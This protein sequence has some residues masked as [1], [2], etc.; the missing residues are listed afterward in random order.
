MAAAEASPRP[1]VA[2]LSL[3]NVL[4]TPEQL[5]RSPSLE[6]GVPAELEYDLRIWG[7]QFIQELGICLRLF[8]QTITHRGLPLLTLFCC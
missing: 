5:A 1:P 6:D 8:A 7:C 4:L 2:L 3:E